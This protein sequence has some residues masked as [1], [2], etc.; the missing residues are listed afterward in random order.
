MVRTCIEWTENEEPSLREGSSIRS[1]LYHF[2]CIHS[3]MRSLFIF[4]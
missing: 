3:S 1:D 4:T 2:F